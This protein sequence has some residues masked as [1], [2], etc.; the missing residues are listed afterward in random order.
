[1]FFFF[2]LCLVFSF[3]LFTFDGAVVVGG[4]AAAGGGGGGG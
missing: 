3:S 1:L 2:V 4:L